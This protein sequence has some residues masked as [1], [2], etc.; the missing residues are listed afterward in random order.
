LA[1]VIGAVGLVARAMAP[2]AGLFGGE[3]FGADVSIEEL[4]RLI[5]EAQWARRGTWRAPSG[6][7][8]SSPAAAS[9]LDRRAALRQRVEIGG[10]LPAREHAWDRGAGVRGSGYRQRPVSRCG[11]Q[12]P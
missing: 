6:R 1:H 2:A 4:V 10:L 11:P 9:L 12:C 5:R 8:F 7:A 3:E